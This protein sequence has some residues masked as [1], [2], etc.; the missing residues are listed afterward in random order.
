MNITGGIYE[1]AIIMILPPGGFLAFGFIM[2]AIN[3]LSSKKVEH[4]G[5]ASCPMPCGVSN[6][7][8]EA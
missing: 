8:E 2:A 6:N 1:P 7:G 5:C 3:K 4:T